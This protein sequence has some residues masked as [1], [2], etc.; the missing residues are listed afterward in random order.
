[1][2]QG[3]ESWRKNNFLRPYSA[4]N[5]VEWIQSGERYFQQIVELID[6]ARF[7]VHL[8]TFIFAQDSTRARGS[9]LGAL[10][11]QGQDGTIKEAL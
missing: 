10:A 2:K 6:S 1:M 11:G 4:N 7:E 5:S 3:F 9:P 8:Q